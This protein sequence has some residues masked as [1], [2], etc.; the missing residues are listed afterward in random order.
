[1]VEITLSIP[2]DL[3][4]FL[5]RQTIKNGFGSTDDYLCHLLDGER[6]KERI[7]G[8]LIEGLESG[9]PI[10]VNDNWWEQKRDTLIK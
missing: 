4:A 10:E 8:M 5:E 1:M 9:K 7:E 2:E 3:Q 6:E